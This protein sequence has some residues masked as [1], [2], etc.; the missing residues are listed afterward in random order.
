MLSTNP[1]QVLGVSPRHSREQV[2]DAADEASLVGDTDACDEARTLLLNP[3]HRVR[4]EVS[5]LSGVSPRKAAELILLLDKD[6]EFAV[7]EKNLPELARFNLIVQALYAGAYVGKDEVF[8]LVLDVLTSAGDDI[9]INTVLRDINEDRVVAK[10]PVLS[11]EALLTDVLHEHMKNAVETVRGA[12]DKL[13]TDRLVSVMTSYA[14]TWTVNGTSV[15]SSFAEMLLD[16]YEIQAHSFLEA[17]IE[18]ISKMI[19]YLRSVVSDRPDAFTANFRKLKSAVRNWDSVAQPAQLLAKARGLNHETSRKLGYLLRSFGVD[20]HNEFDN[21]DAAEEVSR[22]IAELFSEVPELAERVES[23]INALEDIKKSREETERDRRERLEALTY[24]AEIG[25]VF[26]ELLKLTPDRVSYG[27]VGFDLNKITRI[28]WGAIRNSVNGIPAG[29]D[30]TI[31]FGDPSNEAVVALRKGQI[32]EDFTDRLWKAVGIDLIFKVISE[33][34]DGRVY[35][36][37]G[38]SLA[39]EYAEFTKKGGLFSSDETRRF[40]WGEISISSYDGSFNLWSTS[41]RKFYGSMS[42]I[43]TANSHVFEALLRAA[44]KKP[45]LR[46]LSETFGK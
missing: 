25:L 35:R 41:D 23:D 21:T 33:L 10:F 15:Q 1:F 40:N 12:L 5:W 36:F 29:T 11:D 26:K 17:E 30:Y 32:F 18:S 20:L 38:F 19:D 44:F 31:A 8:R 46:R 16:S 13:P 27:D 6:P 34:K 24:S 4:A 7:H 45:G 2:V 43:N 37:S 28:R 42:Y 39:D 3:K 14:D 9:S 22:L